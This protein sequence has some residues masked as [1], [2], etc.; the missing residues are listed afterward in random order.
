HARYWLIIPVFA[1][2]FTSHL[3][4]ALRWK[5]LIGSLGYHAKTSNAFFSVMIGYLTNQAVPRLGEIAKCTM[6]A[7]YENIPADKLIGTIIL[8]RVIDAITL[9]IVFGITLVIQP[10]IYTDLINAFFHSPQDKTQHKISGLLIAAI[11]IGVLV[12][13]ILTWMLIKKKNINDLVKI[14]QRIGKSVWQGISAV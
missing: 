7:R 3:I 13:T 9:L 2:L 8:E 6:L 11:I 14:F 12:I 10:D 1:I 5:L 4:R